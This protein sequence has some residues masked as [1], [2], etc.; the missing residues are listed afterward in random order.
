[1]LWSLNFVDL[2]MTLQ[3]AVA[4]ASGRMG[5][6]LLRIIAANPREYQLSCA[7]VRKESAF[8][9]QPVQSL[10]PQ[11]TN[12]I[13]MSATLHTSDVV[14]DFSLASA[15]RAIIDQCV[16]HSTPLVMCTTGLDVA[17]ELYMQQV[18]L[19][20]PVL[21]AT[22]TSVGI[23][24]LRSLVRQA[25]RA[26]AAADIEIIEAHHKQKIDAPSGVALDLGHVVAQA[27]DIAF[28]DVAVFDRHSVRKQR[29]AGQIGFSS[30]RAA[31]IIGEHTVMFAQEGERLELTHRVMTRS[32]FA[33]G[34]LLAATHIVGCTAT[35]LY[36]MDDMV[37][38]LL[39]Q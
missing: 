24:V 21:Y 15:T 29:M 19:Q 34:A 12:P 18:S 25:S 30:I 14:I 33:R 8:F 2:S 5:R 3:I 16:E 22:N 9:Q 4:G 17:T 13:I 7:L 31:D 23:H 27:R 32:V 1:M 38:Q 10:E 35:K 37:E 28:D 36:V 6:E 26:L 39:T 20:I 11:I